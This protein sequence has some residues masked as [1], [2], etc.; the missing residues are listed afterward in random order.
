MKDGYGIYII[1]NGARYEGHILKFKVANT[2][3]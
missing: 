2:L 1:N 3:K